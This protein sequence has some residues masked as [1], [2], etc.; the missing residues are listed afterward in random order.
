MVRAAV[1]GSKLKEPQLILPTFSA[2][3][4]KKLLAWRPKGFYET[5]LHVF[6]LLLM[7]TGCRNAEA[8]GLKWPDVDLDNLLLKLHGKGGK[9]RLVRFSFELRPQLYRWKQLNR[10]VRVF[11]GQQGQRLGRRNMLRDVKLLCGRFGIIPPA[12]TIHAFRH[13]FAANYLRK[14]GSVFHL[15]KMLGHSTLE[16]TRR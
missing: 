3:D 16:M 7:D 1:E 13:T 15:Q 2:S 9:D 12:R 6:V 5:R 4:I 8:T 10:W 14:G 11:S